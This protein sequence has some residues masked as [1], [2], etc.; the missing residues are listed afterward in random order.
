MQLNDILHTPDI[1]FNKV[2]KKLRE[3][4][5]FEFS[6]NASK[7]FLRKI[8]ESV[9]EDI[10]K[11]KES[12]E[13]VETSAEISERLLILEGINCLLKKQRE[14]NS[15]LEKFTK[16][17]TTFVVEHFATTAKNA[18]DFENSVSKAIAECKLKRVPVPLRL[19]EQRV[20][21]EAVYKIVKKYPGMEQKFNEYLRNDVK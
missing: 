14:T 16:I 9:I 13:V 17:L 4:Y 5:N 7:D 18:E 11:L 10:I 1:T 2:N 21:Q 20:R 6:K 3:Y 19:L 15:G 12:G 8:K